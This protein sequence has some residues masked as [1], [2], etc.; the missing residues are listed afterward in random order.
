MSVN[1][2]DLVLLITVV[3]VI[4]LEFRRGFGKAV[5]DFTAFIVALKVSLA[6]GSALGGLLRFV[7]DKQDNE[8][9][10]FALFFL[11]V[12]GALWLIGKLIYDAT[13]ICIDT[14]DPPI[15][16]VLGFAIAV[17][18]GHAFM[19]T[20]FIASG[21]KGAVP[22]VITDSA[23]GYSFLEFPAYHAVMGFLSSL[24]D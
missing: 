18:V 14:F 7:P 4:W 15:G 24:A 19:Y 23:L 10:V 2:I 5:F 8:A 11:T 3:L 22:D 1:W 13:L 21:A 9:L 20:L 17:I 6:Y 16:A 12:G